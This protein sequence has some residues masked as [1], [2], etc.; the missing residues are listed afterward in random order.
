[1]LPLAIQHCDMMKSQVTFTLTF[2]ED[3][4]ALKQMQQTSLTLVEKVFD[5]SKIFNLMAQVFKPQA[6]QKKVRL[7]FP[8]PL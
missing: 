1:M 7:I 8:Q 5:P 2:V 4:L 6:A 3:L